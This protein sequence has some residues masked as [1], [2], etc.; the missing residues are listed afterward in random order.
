MYGRSTLFFFLVFQLVLS[1]ATADPVLQINPNQESYLLGKFISVFE[2]KTGKISFNAIHNGDHDHEFRTYNVDSPSIGFTNSAIWV[3][4]TIKNNSELSNWILDQRFANTHYMDFYQIQNG[5]INVIQSG[6]LRA[7]DNRSVAHRRI[8][9]KLNPEFEKIE[10]YY[11][12]IKSQAS[13]SLNLQLLSE[14]AFQ[15]FDHL[16]SFWMGL[17]YGMLLIIF[18]INL[19]LYSFIRNITYLYL[20]SFIASISFVFLTFDGYAQFIFSEN[21]VEYSRHILPMGICLS[22]ISFLLFC[23]GLQFY[24]EQGKYLQGLQKILIGIWTGLF[25]LELALDYLIITQISI[26]LLTLTLTFILITGIANWNKHN[27]V[28][29]FVVFGL[30]TLLISWI[31]FS[32]IRLGLFESIIFLENIQ[33]VG[34]VILLLFVSLAVVSHI[35]W[36]Q[37]FGKKTTEKLSVSEQKFQ[38]VFNQT[39]Q[40]IGILSPDGK[41]QKANQTALDFGHLTESDVLGK[42]FWETPWFENDHDLQ[43]KLK[44]SIK[45]ASKGEFVRFEMKLMTP[46]DDVRW[47]DF[48]IKPFFDKNKEIKLLI[49]EGRDITEI[50]KTQQELQETQKQL[51][52]HR[53]NLEHLVDERTKDLH[54]LNNELR[55]FSYSV[56]HDLRA[57]LRSIHGFSQVLFEDYGSKL[58]KTGNQY[59]LRIISNSQHMAELIDDF[60][61]LSQLERNELNREK[62]DLDELVKSVLLNYMNKESQDINFQVSD[63]GTAN[64]DKRLTSIVFENLINNAVKYTSKQ[65]GATIRIGKMKEKTNTIYFVKDNGIGFDMQMAEKIFSPFQRLHK[66]SEYEGSGI[67]LASVQRIVHRH[68]G[69]IWATAE[70]EKGATFYFIL[71]P[72]IE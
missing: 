35:Q 64:V 62:I 48:S 25:V 14:T 17:F 67:G 71:N 21:L 10:T 30:I 3:R 68:R 24:S 16:E 54:S 6:N 20:I 39:F 4:L 37:N 8:L 50:V 19:L 58:D 11:F 23:D 69:R 60:L 44:F 41:I 31:I 28:S 18:L 63:L 34:L 55:L 43:N 26:G 36:L 49:P 42:E 33:R 15:Q 45:H 12:R 2:D 57:P 27:A 1:T 59:L 9:F 22:C 47:I 51:E 66:N 52:S 7:F 5:K 72:E 46:N 53:D 38:A 32:L 29:R 65:P 13:I 61:K 70:P 56:S 40:L